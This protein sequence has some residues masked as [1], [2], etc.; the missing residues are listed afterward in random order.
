MTDMLQ[1]AVNDGVISRPLSDSIFTYF[2]IAEQEGVLLRV[3]PAALLALLEVPLAKRLASVNCDYSNHQGIPETQD[4]LPRR[5]RAQ[6]IMWQEGAVSR[7]A[8]MKDSRYKYFFGSRKSEELINWLAITLIASA[9]SGEATH[10]ELKQ[11]RG[12]SNKLGDAAMQQVRHNRQPADVW[13][14]A[15]MDNF[16]RHPKAMH[17]FIAC[18][19]GR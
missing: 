3:L 1:R 16:S 10:K 12:H 4:I 6:R 7:L 15:Q 14:A 19:F 17:C 9:S 11:A 13:T 2:E 18:R 8:G 5:L